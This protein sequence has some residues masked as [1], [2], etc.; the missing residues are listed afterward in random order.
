MIIHLLDFREVVAAKGE[1]ERKSVISSTRASKSKPE[2]AK[3]DSLDVPI[4]RKLSDLSERELLV[5]PDLGT[6]GE[7]VSIT[8][9]ASISIEGKTGRD[10]PW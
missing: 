2:Q 8:P 3:R 4:K 9:T 7:A 10:E 5:R 1:G 6:R